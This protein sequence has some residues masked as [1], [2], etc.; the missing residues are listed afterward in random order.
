YCFTILYQ[1]SASIS[2]HNLVIYQELT[3]VVT[4]K[5]PALVSI[6]RSCKHYEMYPYR[7]VFSPAP[8]FDQ[9]ALIP[10]SLELEL[11]DT[12]WQ[13]RHKYLLVGRSVVKLKRTI[14]D[15]G[16]LSITELWG[17]R[18]LEKSLEGKSGRINDLR[19]SFD[20]RVGDLRI[21]FTIRQILNLYV[22]QKFEALCGQSVCNVDFDPDSKL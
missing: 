21:Y 3:N 1:L 12:T 16:F 4:L 8:L 22:A 2:G 19:G 5:P 18:G 14:D 20:S 13:K 17:S 11:C 15:V 7:S 9:S 6:N 10:V